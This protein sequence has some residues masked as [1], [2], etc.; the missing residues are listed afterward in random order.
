[1]KKYNVVFILAVNYQPPN[2]VLGNEALAGVR[3]HVSVDA[4]DLE[5]AIQ[6]GKAVAQRL[7]TTGTQGHVVG[8]IA[9]ESA[10]LR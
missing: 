1:M 5:E 8:G 3:I 6:N 4:N 2:A 7:I 10:G 9:V